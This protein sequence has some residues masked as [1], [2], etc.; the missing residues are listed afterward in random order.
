M[1]IY[2]VDAV[3]RDEIEIVGEINYLPDVGDFV[4]I[5]EQC[6]EVRRRMYLSDEEVWIDAKCYPEITG[7]LSFS[8]KLYRS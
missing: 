2:N 6:F 5:N 7:K 3:D 4:L 1:I 8:S